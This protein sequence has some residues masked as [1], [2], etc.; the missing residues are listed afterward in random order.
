LVQP[1]LL[2]PPLFLLFTKQLSI[3]FVGHRLRLLFDQSPD[4]GANQ[5]KHFLKVWLLQ[6][7]SLT[8]VAL[9]DLQA[10][11][12]FDEKGKWIVQVLNGKPSHFKFLKFINT[13]KAFQV[14]LTV[15]WQLFL[16]YLFLTELAGCML[17]LPSPDN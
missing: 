10:Q 17:Q 7:S 5:K 15:G 3:S 11:A 14:S 1:E 13:Q 8:D 6:L 2:F 16:L 12:F 9:V 4:L